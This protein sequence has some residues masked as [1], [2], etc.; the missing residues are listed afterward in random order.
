MTLASSR[1]RSRQSIGRFDVVFDEVLELV[2]G[3]LDVALDARDPELADADLAQ[4][5]FGPLHLLAQVGGLVPPCDVCRVQELRPVLGVLVRE[6]LAQ[7]VDDADVYV[8]AAERIAS[9]RWTCDLEAILRAQKHGGIERA[10][11][12][13][14]DSDRLAWLGC[15]RG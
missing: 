5:L 13:V 11:T 4:G 2:A 8:F 3:E 14:V 15:W 7:V 10:S 1:A 6:D 9:R 12:E